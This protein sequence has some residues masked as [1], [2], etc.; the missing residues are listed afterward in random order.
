MVINLKKF[1]LYLALPLI[2][3]GLSAFIS[4]GGIASYSALSK[5][6]LSPPAWLFP[7]VW[8]L[9]FI[10]MGISSYIASNA[11]ASALKSRALRLYRLQL[12]VNFLWPIFFFNYKLYFFSFLW[13]LLLW[14]LILGTI[15]SFS[16]LSRIA[17][18][19][20]IPYLLWVTFAGYLNLAVFFLNRA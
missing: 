16:R 9:L 13:L 7:I 5:P 3:G 2:T 6:P 18:N 19:L 12:F 11:P 14:F 4:R 8:T 1:I 10:L 20:L 17:A 15:M